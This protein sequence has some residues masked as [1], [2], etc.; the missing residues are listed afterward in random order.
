MTERRDYLTRIMGIL[1]GMLIVLSIVPLASADG[2][3]LGG[4]FLGIPSDLYSRM[5]PAVMNT[6][7]GGTSGYNLWTPSDY[8]YGYPATGNDIGYSRVNHRLFGL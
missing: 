2:G 7:I 3:Y 1:M 4:G 8:Y 6:I 5:D